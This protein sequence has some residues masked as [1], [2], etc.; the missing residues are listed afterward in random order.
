MST[1]EFEVAS[2]P[3]DLGVRAE[4][5]ARG[6]LKVGY[7]VAGLV[8][9][10]FVAIVAGMSLLTGSYWLTVGELQQGGDRYLG[11]RVR[12]SG[13]VLASSEEWNAQEV[14]LRFTVTGEN[15][16]QLP[17]V[18]FGPRPDNFQRATE[19]IIEGELLPDG[20]FQADT[21]LLK[22]PSRYE[23]EPEQIFVESTR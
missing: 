20:S 22:C 9:V 12:V 23:E 16:E 6:G 2:I 3:Q 14:T 15:G 7:I 10:G 5:R 1:Q 19:A 18:F 21:L 17:I 8:V 4:R 13:A 11:E